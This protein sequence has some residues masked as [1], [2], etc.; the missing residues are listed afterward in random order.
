MATTNEV[1]NDMPYLVGVDF[2]TAHGR[3]LH[4]GKSFVGYVATESKRAGIIYKRKTVLYAGDNF[5]FNLPIAEP[6]FDVFVLF[7]VG[8]FVI[9]VGIAAKS[10]V[11]RRRV[12]SSSSH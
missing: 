5:R 1:E 4:L 6:V 12:P 3:K 7:L 11:T 9:G 10:V 8:L 2:N